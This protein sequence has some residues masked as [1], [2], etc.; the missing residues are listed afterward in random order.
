ILAG[1]I[2]GL[3]VVAT[4]TSHSW[5]N[6]ADAREILGRLDT[7]VVQDMYSTTETAAQAHIMLPAAGWGEKEGTF[8]NS[9]RRIGLLKKV[10]R[11]PG[12][13]LADFY[14][15]KLLAEAWGVGDLFRRW[16][17]PEATFQ[18]LKELSRGQPCDFTGI[19]DYGMLDDRRGIQWPLREGER[20]VA[21]SQRRLFADGNFFHSDQKARF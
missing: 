8:I 20:V 17:D 13:A 9:E 15:V 19:E 1:K 18:L 5:I 12:E 14:I 21:Q 11:A 3:W 10:A 4:N 2:H 7:L 6:Q 16:T